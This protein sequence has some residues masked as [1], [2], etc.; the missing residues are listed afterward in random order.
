MIRDQLVFGM[1]PDEK[2]RDK[3]Y[4]TDDLTLEK[5]L[6]LFSTHEIR[7]KLLEPSS[8]SSSVDAVSRRERGAFR[9]RGA[10][11]RLRG[12]G[13]AGGSGPTQMSS[14]QQRPCRNCG[15]VKHEHAWC[16]AE[17]AKCRKCSALGR[18]NGAHLVETD[19]DESR[20]E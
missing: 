16:P 8:S 5:A 19:Q 13:R 11:G 7:K 9:G 1:T 6:K 2:L 14:Q 3:L 12:R 10:R 20:S 18:S 15:N 4:E 17:L